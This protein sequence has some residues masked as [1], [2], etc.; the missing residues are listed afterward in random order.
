MDGGWEGGKEVRRGADERHTAALKRYEDSQETDKP[1]KKRP[2]KPFVYDGKNLSSFASFESTYPLGFA[3]FEE[4]RRPRYLRGWLSPTSK[5]P[6]YV[7]V[8]PTKATVGPTEYGPAHLV[9]LATRL[10]LGPK[11]AEG[12][13]ATYENKFTMPPGIVSVEARTELQSCIDSAGHL[14]PSCF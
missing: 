2:N 3:V 9:A 12:E 11:P 4:D 5:D 8:V 14:P 7:M 10:H 13:K 6:G 1:M